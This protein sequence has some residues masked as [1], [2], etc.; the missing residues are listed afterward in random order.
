M[1]DPASQVEGLMGY[2]NPSIPFYRD[3]LLNRGIWLDEQRMCMPYIREHFLF[4]RFGD[5]TDFVK[6]TFSPSLSWLL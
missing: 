6:N 3:E 4:E 2:F 1:G 5:L